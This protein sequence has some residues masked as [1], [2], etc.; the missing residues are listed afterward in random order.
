VSDTDASTSTSTST[1]APVVAP[2]R[3]LGR[4]ALVIS[5]LVGIVLA[6]LVVLLAT[7]DPATER[8]TDTRLLGRVAPVVEGTTLDGGSISSDDLR[9][10]WVVVNFFASWCTP[11]QLEHPDLLRFD[12]EHRANGDAALIGVT[13]DNKLSD[14]REFFADKGGTWPVIND[15]ENS[16]G[17]AYG[18]TQPPET[19]VISPNGTLVQKF[20]GRV[21]QRDLDRVIAYYEGGGGG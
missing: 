14:A 6:A 19:Y 10:Q 20:V 2:S 4:N 8:K 5:A 11:C 21:T 12:E 16:I 15:P 7:S 17:V 18:V 9:G 3:L 13:F 1:E